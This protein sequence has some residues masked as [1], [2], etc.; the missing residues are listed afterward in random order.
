MTDN[1]FSIPAS[2]EQA[3]KRAY[4]MQER[5]GNL[6]QKVSLSLVY[7]AMAS[8]F[9]V[10]NWPTLQKMLQAKPSARVANPDDEQPY[11]EMPHLISGVRQHLDEIRAICHGK[12]S[13]YHHTNW[14]DETDAEFKLATIEAHVQ[15]AEA[16]LSDPRFAMRSWKLL[17]HVPKEEGIY[18]IGGYT[19]DSDPSSF[20]SAF[21]SLTLTKDGPR[22]RH[23]DNSQLHIPIE[24]WTALPPN[25]KYR[26]PKTGGDKS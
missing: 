15:L 18:V 25:P 10:R 9:G 8:A 14:N 16:F 7:E 5:L 19:D 21:A 26:T 3:K 4:A 20:Q 2:L 23:C 22:W 1:Q 13:D 6:G 12:H 17:R 11:W 24:F